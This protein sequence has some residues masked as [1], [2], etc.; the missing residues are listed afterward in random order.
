MTGVQTCALPISDQ[1][2]RRMTIATLAQGLGAAHGPVL[3]MLGDAMKTRSH[4]S[5]DSE[6]S[7]AIARQLRA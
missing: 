4:Q 3:V 2:I 1:H 7:S 6:I 5:F